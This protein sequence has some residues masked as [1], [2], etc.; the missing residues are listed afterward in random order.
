MITEEKLL[1]I[2]PEIRWFI[3]LACRP[4]F[5]E[6]E[7]MLYDLGGCE[8]PIWLRGSTITK[9]AE[10]GIVLRV[11]TSQGT[12]YESIGVRCMNRRAGR[13][14]SCARLHQ[15]D[16]FQT[17][18]AGIQGGKGVSE[19]VIT[20]PRVFATVTAPSFGAV[21][22][23]TDPDTP[24]DLCRPRRGDPLFEHNLP[25]GCRVRH[26]E[27]EQVIGSPLCPDCYDYPGA[28]L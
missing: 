15:G 11:A 12:P 25:Q 21:H 28:V 6:I 17:I 9:A 14:K 2:D 5:R 18:L 27:G 22:R 8:N 26:G 23:M 16:A 24:G 13:C 4:D 19:S 1:E 7:H 3:R 20:H 10:S